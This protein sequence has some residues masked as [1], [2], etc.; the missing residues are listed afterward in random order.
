MHT[1]HPVPCPQN[2]LPFRN[3]T[4]LFYTSALRSGPYARQNGHCAVD[5]CHA[6]WA[7]PA[8]QRIEGVCRSMTQDGVS[9]GA[10]QNH[11]APARSEPAMIENVSCPA[12][13]HIV[14]AKSVIPMPATKIP[15]L[16]EGASKI[17][18]RGIGT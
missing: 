17:Q 8:A 9:G 3:L 4:N 15:T 7:D 1:P 18:Q 14:R 12:L 10:R 13:P 6:D 2:V 11:L 5:A 16:C